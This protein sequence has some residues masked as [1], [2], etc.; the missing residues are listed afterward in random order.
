MS[1]YKS[2]LERK[3]AARNPGLKYEATKLPYVVTH[4]YTPD[5]SL[6]D[7]LFV[8]TKGLF[9]S[10]DRA[11]HLHI[12]KQHPEVKVLFVFQNPNLRLTK[13]S[14]TTYAEWCTAHGI[15]F[16]HID[17]IESHTSDTLRALLNKTE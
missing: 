9:T 3:F 6:G 2:G 1:K 16:L 12:K 7:N 4:T 15:K 17:Q 11:K 10:A 5:F 14:R 13:A 8:E